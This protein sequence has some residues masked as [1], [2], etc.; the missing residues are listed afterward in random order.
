MSVIRFKRVKRK[1][2]MKSRTRSTTRRAGAFGL[3]RGTRNVA[4]LRR[5]A[6][7][8][9]RGTVY[10]PLT[11]FPNS[12]LVRHKYVDV[13]TM[14]A[15]GG[16]GLSTTYQ[17]RTNSMYDPDYTGVGHQPLFRD[18]MAAQYK[19]YTVLYSKIKVTF[20]LGTNSEFAYLLW[21]D[22]DTAVPSDANTTQEQHSTRIERADKRNRPFTL[23]GYFNAAKWFRTNKA[24][25]LADDQQKVAVGTNPGSGV[26]KYY[27]IYV[28]PLD[29][30]VTVPAT[31][32]RVEMSFITLW[33]EPI[34]HVGS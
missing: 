25:L 27:Q 33:R 20:P 11:P 16:P 28:A 17:F 34:D 18:E 30:T 9:G 22:D 21:A 7:S 8:Y 6:R 19:S 13:V 4:M 26:V 14:S 12:K 1:A 5:A 24:G 32:I 10:R 3:Y 29:T 23:K 31:K 15:G 2:S